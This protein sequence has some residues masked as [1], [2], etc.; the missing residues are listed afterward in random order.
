MGDFPLISHGCW[1]AGSGE[2][3]EFVRW[4][5]LLARAAG[6]GTE[7][8]ELGEFTRELPR[9][10]YDNLTLGNTLGDWDTLPKDSLLVV[11]AHSDED[12]VIYHVHALQVAERLEELIPA[13]AV[14][15]HH[16]PGSILQKAERA[17]TI[18]FIAGLK[19]AAAGGEDVTF[20][21]GD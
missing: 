2:Y 6:I 10:D 5:A 18:Q 4:R 15:S 1:D 16:A 19:E 3:S 20:Q 13:L 12:G 11:L 21:Q 14:A 9:L 17:R 7:H 8:A